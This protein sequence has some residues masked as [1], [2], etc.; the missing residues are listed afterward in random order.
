[1]DTA[2]EIIADWYVGDALNLSSLGLTE[3]PPIPHNVEWLY[4]DNNALIELPPLPPA[5]VVLNCRGNAI[6][7]LPRLPLTLASLARGINPIQ[8][9][10]PDVFMRGMDFLKQWMDE[11]PP[12]SY[13]KSANK[14]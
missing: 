11:N 12:P 14:V 3:L 6:T 7:Q 4:C 13:I 5:L 10:P 8:Y 2:L 9:P 1:M